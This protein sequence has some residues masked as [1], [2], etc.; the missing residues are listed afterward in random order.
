V[1]FDMD[2]SEN[3]RMVVAAPEAHYGRFY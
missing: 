3:G 1:D 2:F